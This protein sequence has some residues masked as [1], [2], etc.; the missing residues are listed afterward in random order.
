M[1]RVCGGGDGGLRIDERREKSKPN[2]IHDSILKEK[3]RKP[4]MRVDSFGV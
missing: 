2:K 4:D 1:G 3:N